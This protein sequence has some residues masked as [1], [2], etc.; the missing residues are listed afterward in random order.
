MTAKEKRTWVCRGYSDWNAENDCANAPEVIGNDLP[1]GEWQ[2]A[3][4]AYN[5]GTRSAAMDYHRKVA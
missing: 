2:E 1:A 3:Q 4:A 5:S